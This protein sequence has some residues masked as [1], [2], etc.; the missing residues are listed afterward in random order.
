[1][2]FCPL[3]SGSSGNLSFVEAGGM[4]LLVDCGFPASRAAAALKERGIAPDSING[5]LVTH[6]HSDHT[7]GVGVFSRRYHVPVYANEATF[8]AML[9]QIGKLDP[10]MIRVFETG[11]DFYL[12]QV[13]ILPVPIPHDAAE[14]VCYV[15]TQQGAKLTLMTD[16]GRFDERMRMAAQGS[17]LILIESNHD[18]D[19]LQAG[20]YPYPLK[21]RILGETGHLSNDACGQALVELYLTGVHRAILGHLSGDNNLEPLAM[22]TVRAALREAD[23]PDGEFELTLAHRERVGEM[24]LIPGEAG[25]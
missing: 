6:D 10:A 4:R 9:P 25:A 21:R 17:G 15:F 22:A 5:I 20:R 3:Y 11:R 18:I 24:Y 19:M 13:N 16:I 7:R 2:R 12:G 1:M 14:P 23:I 8:R